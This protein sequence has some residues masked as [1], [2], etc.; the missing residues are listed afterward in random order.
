MFLKGRVVRVL[1]FGGGRTK[2]PSELL[3]FENDGSER[4]VEEGWSDRG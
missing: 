4:E 3:S 2:S 1:S